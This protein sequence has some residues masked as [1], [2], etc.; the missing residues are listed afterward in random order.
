MQLG[1]HVYV[2]SRSRLTWMPRGHPVRH[3]AGLLLLTFALN[4]TAVV[5][6]RTWRRRFAGASS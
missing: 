4:A 5:V 3:S 2:L 1:Y 6:R